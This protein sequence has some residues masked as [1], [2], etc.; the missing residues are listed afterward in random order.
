MSYYVRHKNELECN[1]I[2]NT[3]VVETKFSEVTD[4][5]VGSSSSVLGKD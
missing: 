3:P 2:N 1:I 4:K 5:R